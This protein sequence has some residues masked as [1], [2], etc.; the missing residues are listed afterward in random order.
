MKKLIIL[1]LF[2][3]CF[4]AKAEEI[5][6]EQLFVYYKN[7]TSCA[8]AYNFQYKIAAVTFTIDQGVNSQRLLESIGPLT[9]AWVTIAMRLENELSLK[10]GFTDKEIGDY[11][12]NV[13]MSTATSVGENLWLMNKANQFTEHLFASTDGCNEL[14]VQIRNV[15]KGVLDETIVAP[16]LEQGPDSS[17]NKPKQKM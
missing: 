1:L 12:S 9:T 6:K 15:F 4:S 7:T 16:K 2:L 5:T 14:A 17:L 11:R 13:F 8:V 3:G 10:H